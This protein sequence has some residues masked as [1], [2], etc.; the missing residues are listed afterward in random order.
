[1]PSKYLFI[2]DQNISSFIF[3]SLSSRNTF[4]I[5]KFVCANRIVKEQSGLH[6]TR[7]LLVYYKKKKGMHLISYMN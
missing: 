6:T 4:P 3:Y 1:M 5:Q 2:S 7:L